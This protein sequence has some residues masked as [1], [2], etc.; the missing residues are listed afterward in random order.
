MFLHGLADTLVPIRHARKLYAALPKGNKAFIQVRGTDSRESGDGRRLCESMTI[1][2]SFVQSWLGL[3]SLSWTHVLTVQRMCEQ[4]A[5]ANH[6][7]L[8]LF[9][10]YAE[11]IALWM[12]KYVW[13]PPPRAASAVPPASFLAKSGSFS[14]A[15]SRAGSLQSSR[16]GS[17]T[18]A[19]NPYRY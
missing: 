8:P 7:E 18:R 10:G 14:R 2:H 19:R 9:E 17:P 11:Q 13:A 1:G 6:N 16:Q 4:I 3:W 12:D 5:G 15:G